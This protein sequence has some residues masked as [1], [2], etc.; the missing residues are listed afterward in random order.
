METYNMFNHLKAEF[1]K[2]VATTNHYFHI[3]DIRDNWEFLGQAEAYAETLRIIGH[4]VLLITR[5]REELV[6]ITRAT[7]NGINILEG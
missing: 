6:E 4:T 3:G 2:S 5:E 7:V 1:E